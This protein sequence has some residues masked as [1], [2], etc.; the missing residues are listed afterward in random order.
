MKEETASFAAFARRLG[1][2]RSYVTELRKADRLVLT[3]DGKAVRV[4]ESMARIEATRDPAKR[5]VAARH[6]AARATGAANAPAVAEPSHEATQAPTFVPEAR[7]GQDRI[8][9]TY[10]A[11]RAVRERY[12]A[13]Q[14]KV[15]YERSIGKLLNG[16]DVESAVFASITTLRVRL[17]SLPG[18]VSPRLAAETD[19]PKIAAILAEEIEHTLAECE[20]QFQGI[21]KP[22][23]QPE[24]P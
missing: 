4:A 2:K 20:R 10:Q 6:A 3:D 8:T 18:V 24:T 14:A 19:E 7:E 15:D 5:G 11:S 22:P 13:M 21:A 9:G 23:D 1:C 16:A 12:L 17:E